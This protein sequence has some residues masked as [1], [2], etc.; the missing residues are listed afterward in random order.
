M[1]SRLLKGD[2][3]ERGSAA[4]VCLVGAVVGAYAA[5]GLKHGETLALS[6]I[7]WA[8]ALTALSGAVLVAVM[9]HT[10]PATASAPQ[11]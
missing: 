1:F 5:Y 3:A 9:V 4:L 11:P 2:L 6:P 10:K 8:G 7:Q